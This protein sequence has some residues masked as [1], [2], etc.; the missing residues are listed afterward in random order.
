MYKDRNGN[1]IEKRVK[2]D[3]IAAILCIPFVLV[4]SEFCDIPKTKKPE[5]QIHQVDTGHVAPS[6]SDTLTFARPHARTEVDAYPCGTRLLGRASPFS[7]PKTMSAHSLQS[8]TSNVTTFYRSAKSWRAFSLQQITAA[9]PTHQPGLKWMYTPAVCSS[10]IFAKY[11]TP[12]WCSTDRNWIARRPFVLS[13]SRRKAAF[14]SLS[15]HT[16]F[17]MCII[18]LRALAHLTTYHQALYCSTGTK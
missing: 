12:F 5:E 10:A 14:L 15:R 6:V 2:R 9:S 4:I 8:P 3:I 18:A 11:S 13:R 1:L 16:R 17:C 7:A